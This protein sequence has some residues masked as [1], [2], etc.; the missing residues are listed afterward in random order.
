MKKI[1]NQ[2]GQ[3]TVEFIF[4]FVFAIGLIL[5]VF[6]ASVNYATGY[7]VHYATFMSS[8]VFLTQGSYMA[9]WGPSM[10]EEAGRNAEQ[11]FRTYNL[12]F[13][14]VPSDAFKINDGPLEASADQ[15]LMIGGYTKF[16]RKMDVIGQIAGQ[17]K[18]ELVSE[19]FLG[20]EPT[21]GVCAARVCKAITGQDNCQGS[22]M[23]I[24]LFDNGC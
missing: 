7:V 8:R 24:T 11:F 9:T 2:S 6:N 3:S 16:S 18:L 15:Y 5:F 4:C 20:R 10:R 1:T 17:K 13:F 23:D 21:Q 14:G 22:Q 19:S 12:D